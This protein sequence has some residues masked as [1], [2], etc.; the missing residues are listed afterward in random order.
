MVMR[1]VDPGKGRTGFPKWLHG[2]E[3]GHYGSP[4]F[5]QAREQSRCGVDGGTWVLPRRRCEDPRPHRCARVVLRCLARCVQVQ[6]ELAIERGDLQIPLAL[7][8]VS[9]KSSMTRVQ[10]GALVSK[11]SMAHGNLSGNQLHFAVGSPLAPTAFAL[12][13]ATQPSATPAARRSLQ[14]QAMLAGE[15]TRSGSGRPSDQQG[16]DLSGNSAAVLLAAAQSRDASR[17]TAPRDDGGKAQNRVA[18]WLSSN[19]PQPTARLADVHED[20]TGEAQHDEADEPGDEHDEEHSSELDEDEDEDG[21]VHRVV[22]AACFF[23]GRDPARAVPAADALVAVRAARCVQGG[24][25]MGRVKKQA[26]G[27]VENAEGASGTASE[28][29]NDLGESGRP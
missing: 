8:P 17:T 20:E 16:P 29:E 7:R 6:K 27:T 25:P 21:S 2:V 22:S 5:M 1:V 14:A 26:W 11:P 23:G 4:A 15:H 24:A 12:A 9:A 10:G 13:N 19:S 3:L 18:A 28:P